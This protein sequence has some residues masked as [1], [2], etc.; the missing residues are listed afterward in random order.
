VLVRRL[1][2][3]EALA[4]IDTVVFDK[5][6]TLTRDRVVL[7][8][9]IARDGISERQ[10]LRQ[11][12]P[13]ARA[14]L[15]P[16]S[17]AIARA[18]EGSDADQQAFCEVQEIP[19]QGLQAGQ[20]AALLRLGSAAFCA[21]DEPELLSFGRSVADAPCAYLC[22]ASGWLATFVL[23]RGRARGGAGLCS[24]ACRAM[25]LHLR[26]LSITR[27]AHREAETAKAHR[28]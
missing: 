23:R 21:L 4:G 12:A 5:T 7:R 14:S 8:Q 26:L 16:V 24:P 22:D 11:A 15:H 20:G 28:G 17:R 25:G 10:A 9:V 13:L 18:L 1:Q 27:R 3:F 19:G 6:G 2:A